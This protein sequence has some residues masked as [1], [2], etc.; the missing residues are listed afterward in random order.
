MIEFVLGIFFG[1]VL[2]RGEK[3][4]WYKDGFRMALESCKPYEQRI[5]QEMANIF[6]S[7]RDETHQQRFS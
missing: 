2:T 1:V 3:H 7:V 5:E 6:R 4:F